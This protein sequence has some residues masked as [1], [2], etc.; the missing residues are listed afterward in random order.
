MQQIVEKFDNKNKAEKEK[1]EMQY[2]YH[3][4]YIDKKLNV[5]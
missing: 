4:K 3:K 5:D 2:F 1:E